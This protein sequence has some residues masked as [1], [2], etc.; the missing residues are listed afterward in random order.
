MKLNHITYSKAPNNH[1]Y[2]T[3]KAN[4]PDGYYI[5]D[6][7]SEK[8]GFNGKTTRYKKTRQCILCAHSWNVTDSIRKNITEANIRHKTA[9]DKFEALQENKR[10]E[11]ANAYY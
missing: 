6:D 5:G 9:L 7:C 3:N 8:H 10:L 4:L 2:L 1:A 11:R